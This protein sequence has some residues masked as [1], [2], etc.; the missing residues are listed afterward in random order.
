[1][2][3]RDPEL[4]RAVDAATRELSRRVAH[5]A[6]LAD[7]DAWAAA[8]IAA[9]CEEGWRPVPRPAE[10]VIASGPRD[11]DL[12][13]RRA[14]EARAALRE[15]RQETERAPAGPEYLAAPQH[16]DTRDPR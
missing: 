11:P 6:A 14:A 15:R 4:Q 3:D 2:T 1:M 8:F 10:A 16:P 13:H 7:P 12:A 9:M 5:V